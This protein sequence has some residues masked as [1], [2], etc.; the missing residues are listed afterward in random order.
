MSEAGG[1]AVGLTGKDGGM[2]R[3]TKKMLPDAEHPGELLDIGFVGDIE[4]IQPEVVKALQD[5]QFIPVISSIGYGED[6]QAYNINAD[7][8]GNQ[9]AQALGAEVA[10]LEATRTCGDVTDPSTCRLASNALLAIGAPSIRGET[11]TV[12]VYVWYRQDDVHSPVGKATWDVR[13]RRSGSGWTVD[14][15]RLL[16]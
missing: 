1:K 11:A 5:D 4:S 2:I 3:V 7:V 6:G 12:R 13:L 9:V 16:D 8:V 15:E 14:G 10:T